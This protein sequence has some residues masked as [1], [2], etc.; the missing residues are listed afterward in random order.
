MGGRWTAPCPGFARHRT[1][2]WTV[3]LIPQSPVEKEESSLLRSFFLYFYHGIRM[4]RGIWATQ[5]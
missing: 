3:I 2:C 5:H 1:A 4:T